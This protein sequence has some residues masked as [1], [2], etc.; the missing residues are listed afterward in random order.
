MVHYNTGCSPLTECEANCKIII[1]DSQHLPG[2]SDQFFFHPPEKVS[3]R[4]RSKE[5]DYFLCAEGSFL[6]VFE[7]TVCGPCWRG[8]ELIV[9]SSADQSEDAEKG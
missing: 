2:G 1:S 7:H 8:A 4:R 6:R 9:C 3:W 5:G